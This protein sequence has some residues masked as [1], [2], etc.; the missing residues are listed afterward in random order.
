MN[1][2]PPQGQQVARNDLLDRIADEHLVAELD[3]PFSQ[4]AVRSAWEEKNALEVEG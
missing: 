2:S 3:F 1:R 4:S